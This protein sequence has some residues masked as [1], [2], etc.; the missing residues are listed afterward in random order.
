MQI[1]DLFQQVG[2][3]NHP[4]FRVV[5]CSGELHKKLNKVMIKLLV[6]LLHYFA[7]EPPSKVVSLHPAA[8][9]EF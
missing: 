4:L 8:R 7:Q 6:V 3:I 1:S 5:T 2:H 9:N